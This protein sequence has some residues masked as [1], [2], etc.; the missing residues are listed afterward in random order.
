MVSGVPNGD[1]AAVLVWCGVVDT[2]TEA[3]CSSLVAKLARVHEIF[4]ALTPWQ[5]FER[6]CVEFALGYTEVTS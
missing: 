4:D 2:S 6:I 3:C 1:A 5:R